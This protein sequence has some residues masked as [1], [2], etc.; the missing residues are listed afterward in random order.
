V[1]EKLASEADLTRWSLEAGLRAAPATPSVLRRALAIREA[2][3]RVLASAVSG[4]RPAP[5]DLAALNRELAIAR[6]HER[7]RHTA[8]GFVIGWDDA[9]APDAV[10]WNIA[11]SAAELLQS[12]YLHRLRQCGG[13]ECGWLFLDTSRN[14]SRRWCDMR[15]CG[16]RNKVLQ[17]RRRAR[18]KSYAEKRET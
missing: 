15:D 11:R 7:I 13:Y 8:R 17:F 14:H 2:L 5:A 6:S 10:L 12:G 4:S 16:N 1:R 3:Y 18:A 9:D